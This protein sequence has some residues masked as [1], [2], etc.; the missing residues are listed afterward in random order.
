MSSEITKKGIE[1]AKKAIELDRSQ[2]YEQALALYKSASEYLLKG[3]QY[4]SSQVKQIIGKKCSEYLERAEKIDSMLKDGTTKKAVASGGEGTGEDDDDD[5]DASGLNPERK[6]L[7]QALES[8]VVIEKPNIAW[9]DVAG[10]D[11]AKEALQEAVIL[12]MRLP[13]MF[14]GKREPWRGILLYGPPGTG[15]SYLAKAVASEAN[16]STFIS[17]S[18]SDLVSKW[19]GQSERLVK[20]LFEMAREKSPCIVFVDEIDSLCSAR[21]D[22]ESESS[23]RI[24]TEFLVQMQGVGSQ[25]DGIL[26]V[27]ATNI[28][29]QLDSAIRRRFEK[30]IYIALPDTEARCKMFELHIKGVRNTLQPHDYNTLAHKSEGYSGSD[31]CN[32][33]R[34]AIMM[35]VRKVQHAQAFKKCDENGYPTPSGAFWTPCS[36][37]DR[38]PTKQFMSWQDMPAEAIVEPPV[39]MRDMVQA[40]ERTK[41]SVDPKDL[42]KIEEFT[43]SFGQDI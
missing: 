42:G 35:P 15:K 19:Q 8:A 1:V 14:K 32:V 17:V 7:R 41:R 6:Q 34:E 20:E 28:P 23:R 30:R 24:K 10:L 3:M 2:E 5:A 25:N 18:S 21:S 37:S 22:N 33:V 12:P 38:D 9:K 29:W 39:D 26:V 27:G 36:P 11:S 13:Q 31:I 16:N 43:R 4:E 40:L